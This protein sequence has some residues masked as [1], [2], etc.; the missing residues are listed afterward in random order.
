MS[1]PRTVKRLRT[2]VCLPA[3]FMVVLYPHGCREARDR[4]AASHPRDYPRLYRG[5]WLSAVGPGDRRTGRALVLLDDSRAPQGPRAARP[6]LARPDQTPGACVRRTLRRLATTPSSFPILGRVA[7]GV[8]I[9]AQEDVEGEF[10]LPPAFVPRA[11]DA[12]MLRVQGD[13]MIDA[14]ILDGDLIVVRPQRTAD[15]GE[16]VVAMLDGEATVKRFYR[17]AGRDSAA[18]GESHDG[19]N[20]RERCRDRRTRRSGRPPTLRPFSSRFRAASSCPLMRRAR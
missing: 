9:T 5:A 2:Y 1:R 12:F 20:L 11:S 13:S 16:I 6:D 15:N 8:P 19:A 14:A 17:E 3:A 4:T 7:A 18:A 10:V